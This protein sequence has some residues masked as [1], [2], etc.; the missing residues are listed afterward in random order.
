MEKG[1]NISAAIMH[2][3]FIKRGFF[4]SS[5]F[6]SFFPLLPK[7]GNRVLVYLDNLISIVVKNTGGSFVRGEEN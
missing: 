7:N 5:F 2:A 3:A 1:T 6:L 4:F